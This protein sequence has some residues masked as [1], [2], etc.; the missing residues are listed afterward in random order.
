[1]KESYVRSQLQIT[2]FNSEDVIITSTPDPVVEPPKGDYML[3]I[4]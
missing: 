4:R 2:E 3:P 1:M